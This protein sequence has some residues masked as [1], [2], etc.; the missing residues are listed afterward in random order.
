[1]SE[2]EDIECILVREVRYFYVVFGILF[3]IWRSGGRCDSMI[4]FEIL[5][6][7]E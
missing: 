6:E 7:V 3:W 5:V 1:M 4:K 2:G